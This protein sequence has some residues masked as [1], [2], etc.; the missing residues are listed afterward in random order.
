MQNGA[1]LKKRGLA[2]VKQWT[3]T[4]DGLRHLAAE[5]NRSTLT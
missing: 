5:T 3:G 2:S 1:R 4:G